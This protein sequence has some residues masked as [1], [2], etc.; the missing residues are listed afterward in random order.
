M[1]LQRRIDPAIT[2]TMEGNSVLAGVYEGMP[3]VLAFVA[4]LAM[5]IVPE[6]VRLEEIEPHG[7]RDVVVRA[8]VRLQG[9]SGSITTRMVPVYTFTDEGQVVAVSVAAL[10]QRAFDDLVG[11]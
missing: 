8:M 4:K 6:S 7:D 5:W 11:R 3:S 1:T 2:L 9:V 10:D